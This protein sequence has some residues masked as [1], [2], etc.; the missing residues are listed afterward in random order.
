MESLQGQIDKVQKQREL[1]DARVSLEGDLGTKD[2]TLQ[3]QRLDA[4]LAALQ[5]RASLEVQR[6]AIA[7]QAR[8][9]DLKARLDQ[10]AA[11]INNIKVRLNNG[12]AGPQP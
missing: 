6:G 3:K 4:E 10:L 1:L 5:A 9:D 8:V 2:L 12:Q 7:E 11:E